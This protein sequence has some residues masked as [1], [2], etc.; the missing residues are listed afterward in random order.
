MKTMTKILFQ[1][2]WLKESRKVEKIGIEREEFI[3][4]DSGGKGNISR[5]DSRAK[6]KRSTYKL[7]IVL[8]LAAIR[9]SLNTN[10]YLK[11]NLRCL[12]KI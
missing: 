5:Y 12:N 6:N 8:R 11:K 9:I 10:L 4:D 2:I 7:R 3:Q 1:W